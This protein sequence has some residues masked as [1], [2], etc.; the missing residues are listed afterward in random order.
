MVSNALA[1]NQAPLKLYPQ[2][3]HNA[4]C[5]IARRPRASLAAIGKTVGANV[6][7]DF[8]KYL[9]GTYTR[10]D[11]VFTHG[12]GCTL[13]DTEGRQYL[14][15]SGGIAV[16]A[17]GHSDPRWAETVAKQAKKLTHTS[18]LF[19]TLPAVDLAKK[20]VET[21]FADKV[22]YCNS[23]TEANE[24]AMKF[25][26]KW[27]RVQA[28]VDVLDP[29]A[30]APY[31]FV[32]FTAGFH[33][34]TMGALSLTYKDSYRTP[35]GP[36]PPGGNFAEWGNLESAKKA[37]QPGKTCAVFVEPVQVFYFWIPVTG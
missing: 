11:V 26:R 20:L 12:S 36:L 28:G 14:D 10:P 9:V 29:A 6:A 21:S 19:H 7:E 4:S 32:A 8:G 34:R 5:S 2:T 23:G 24:A 18:N 37:I 27:A 15:F 16:N 33:G 31:E 30:Q 25:A 3:P 13:V 22:F 1:A 35:F 17:L